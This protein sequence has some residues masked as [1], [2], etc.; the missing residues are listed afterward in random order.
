MEDRVV[1]DWLIE[2]WDSIVKIVRYWEKLPE[3]KQPASKNFLKVQE[4]VND[5]FAVASRLPPLKNHNFS[6]CVI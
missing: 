1:A 2:I 3:S 5:K 4:A 6:K